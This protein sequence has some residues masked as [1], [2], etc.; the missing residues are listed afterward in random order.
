MQTQNIETPPNPF[1]MT[2]EPKKSLTIL[3]VSD[4]HNEHKKLDKLKLWFLQKFQSKVD[5]IFAT[6]DFD[7]INNDIKVSSSD[8]IQYEKI[9]NILSFL[10]FAVVPVI[11]LPGNHDAAGL[12]K[13]YPKLTQHSEML[14]IGSYQLAEGLQAVGVGGSS[15]A[16]I[17]KNGK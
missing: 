12:F 10:E 5:Y 2:L 13:E 3:L 16:Y 9:T 11:Y 7:T 17:E 15:P 14:H 4:I 6:G 8:P 1:D